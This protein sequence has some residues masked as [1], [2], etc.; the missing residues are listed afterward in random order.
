M[1]GKEERVSFEQSKRRGQSACKRW[2]EERK[3]NCTS[4]REKEKK[5]AQRYQKRG[6]RSL[7][8]KKG[9]PF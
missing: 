6:K 1:R 2:E 9:M 5:K 4:W 8:R 3:R 7:S